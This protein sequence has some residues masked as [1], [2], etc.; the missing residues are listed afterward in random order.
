MT[1]ITRWDVTVSV[2]LLLIAAYNGGTQTMLLCVTF[3]MLIP[4]IFVATWL[5]PFHPHAHTLGS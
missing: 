2:S 4:E 3:R 5:S 1:S